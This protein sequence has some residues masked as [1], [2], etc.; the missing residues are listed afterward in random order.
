[1]VAHRGALHAA[2]EH[3]IAAYTDA[4]EAGADALECDVR[5]TR[6]GH[7]V[8]VQDRRIDR[9]STGIGPVSELDLAQLTE[10]DFASWRRPAGDEVGVLTFAR[11]L[12]LV[13]VR[14]K[15]YPAW[16]DGTLPAGVRIAGPSI[17]TV[18]RHPRYVSRLQ[19]RGYRVHV[20]TADAAAD[21]DLVLGLGV[22]AII[23]N[24][25]RVV[26]ARVGR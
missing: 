21:V 10:L 22:D 17:R 7:L 14:E 16:R 26:L 23:T 8:C 4:L 18:R 24:R 3:T 12:E 20:W 11:L 2:A 6:D 13:L 15:T 25:P 19:A 5:L 9:T 1:M